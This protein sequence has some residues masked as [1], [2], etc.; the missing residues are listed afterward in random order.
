MMVITQGTTRTCELRVGEY[1]QL[2]YS[3]RFLR[4]WS[5]DQPLFCYDNDKLSKPSTNNDTIRSSFDCLCFHYLQITNDPLNKN[6][7]K[8]DYI[9]FRLYYFCSC[10]F[11]NVFSIF[12]MQISISYFIRWPTHCSGYSSLYNSAYSHC[13]TNHP[14][15][16]WS[17]GWLHLLNL[18]YTKKHDKL[19]WTSGWLCGHYFQSAWGWFTLS[20]YSGLTRGHQRAWLCGATSASMLEWYRI[21]D[22][23]DDLIISF[24]AF[25]TVTFCREMG[26]E[27]NFLMELGEGFIYDH[28]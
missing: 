17:S 20:S 5:A 12:I 21:L 14:K 18:R 9:R 10:Y 28:D 2:T 22:D 15:F 19:S 16:N 24:L 8:N 27:H 4:M 7:T 3:R 1:G 11:Q 6:P 26:E 25:G 23:P 13:Q